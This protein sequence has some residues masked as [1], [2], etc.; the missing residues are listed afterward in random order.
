MINGEDLD[1][2]EQLRKSENWHEPRT[3]EEW[4]YSWTLEG[5]EWGQF[6]EDVRF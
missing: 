4:S 1:L 3:G 5:Q 2:E 6:L